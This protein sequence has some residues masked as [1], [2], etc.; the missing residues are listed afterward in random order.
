MMHIV[1]DGVALL[2]ISASGIVV[3]LKVLVGILLS[4]LVES[5]ETFPQ[6][7]GQYN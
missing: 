7:V 6:P 1:F 2:L 4:V 5:L 3:V